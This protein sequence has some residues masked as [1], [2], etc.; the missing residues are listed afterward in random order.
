[1]CGHQEGSGNYKRS[2]R[3]FLRGNDAHMEGGIGELE[4]AIGDMD[5]FGANES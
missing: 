1:M 2:A 3:I 4:N 5:A